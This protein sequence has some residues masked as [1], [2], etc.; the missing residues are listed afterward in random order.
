LKKYQSGG[1]SANGKG[2]IERRNFSE[3]NIVL[4][5]SNTWKIEKGAVILP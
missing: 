4:G 2:I 3:V 5:G 1:M